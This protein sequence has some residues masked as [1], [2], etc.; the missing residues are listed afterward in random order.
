MFCNARIV[1]L[2]CGMNDVFAAKIANE[3]RDIAQTLKLIQQA[4]THSTNPPET[5]KRSDTKRPGRPDA[6]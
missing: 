3:L 6:A 1:T 2:S 5:I 4:L